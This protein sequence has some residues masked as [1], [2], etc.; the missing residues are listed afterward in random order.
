[1]ILKYILHSIND[2]F[3]KFVYFVMLN[4]VIGLKFNNNQFDNNMKFELIKTSCLQMDILERQTHSP[5]RANQ[6]LVDGDTK[7]AHRN[8]T[9]GTAL[10]QETRPMGPIKQKSHYNRFCKMKSTL[11]K[12]SI[13]IHRVL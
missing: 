9:I 6:T 13:R 2:T 3:K 7:L 4:S 10:R 5:K 11:G 12:F 1:M 8:L